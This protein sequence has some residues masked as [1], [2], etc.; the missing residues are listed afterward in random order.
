MRR[1]SIMGDSFASM[2]ALRVRA[3][4]WQGRY[5]VARFDETAEL[6]E[7]DAAASGE[8]SPANA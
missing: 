1:I 8:E 2:V 6:F 4:R 5:Q 7:I 3:V